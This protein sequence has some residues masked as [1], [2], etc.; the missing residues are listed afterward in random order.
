MTTWTDEHVAEALRA[1]HGVYA[2]AARYLVRRHGGRCD[3]G[4]IV[5]RVN[6]CPTLTALAQTIRES[7]L[8]QIERRMR[9]LT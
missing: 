4:R 3:Y 2:D 7:A 1:S 8:D 5:E 6:A 9:L